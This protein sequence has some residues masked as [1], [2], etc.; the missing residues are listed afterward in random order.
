MSAIV[1]KR[2]V[3]LECRAF[4]LEWEKYFFTECFGQAQCL[5]CL[6]TVAVIKEYNVRRHWETQHQ[7]SS[8]ASMSAA[9]R[10]E[11]I[12]TLSGNLQKSTLLFRKQ[13][14]KADK[15]TRAS[16]EVSRFLAR[17][18]KPFTDGDFIKECIMVVIDSLC[19]EKRSA[20]ESVSLSPRT[21]CRRIEMSHSVNDSL[22]TCC[23]NFDAFSLA[24]DE[25]T[26]MKDTA[27]LTIFIRGVTAALQV[28]EEFLQLV[29]LHGTTTGQDIFDAVLQ[30]VKQHSLGLVCVTTDG[31]PAMTG[32]KKGAASLLVRHCEAA[33]HTQPIHKMHCI[34]HQESLCSRSANL[35]D[36]MS[37]VVKVVNSI[38][39]RSLNHRQFQA[40]MDE[41]N[42]HYGD[43][44]YFCEIRWL[45][46]GAMLSRVC[47]LLQE[48]ATF[49]RQK[50]LPGADH[51]SNPQ[52]LARLALLTDITTHLN[53]LNMNLQ[54]KN[55]L[56]T[57][58]YSHITAFEVKLRLWEA[59]L[60]AGQF[61]HFP[62]IAACAP[63]DVDLNT[64]VGIVTSLREEFTSRFTGVRPLA[65]GFKLFTSPF[66]FAVDEAPAPL[67]MELV[68]L[69]CND[70]LKAKYRTA[71]PLSFFRDLV[72]PSNKFPNYIE[73]VKC[74]VAMFGSTYCCE[75][76]FL[77]MKYTK[78]RIR[79]QLSDRHLNDILLLSTSSIDPDIESLLHGKQHQPS[80]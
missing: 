52:W 3:D 13:T 22:K 70:E 58:M 67:Q 15:V 33:G 48:I 75:Q 32:K 68:E 8:F 11:A 36:V 60:A 64:C 45:S 16:Y 78:S 12:V 26:D 72:L 20:F 53:D 46:H 42:A 35:T 65:L 9:E 6:K 62:R 71:S 44:L 27:Q 49:L 55:I 40:L 23:S 77:K 30:C 61:M 4:N 50:N 59:Q 51:F 80:H 76:L 41:V 69:Q 14:T 79:S 37:V 29:P 5:I 66:D 56:V 17:R 18:M 38:L 63:D 31:A 2:K 54:G 24:L 1:K 34:I 43:L 73:H 19:P 39:S 28:Y 7:A 10:K 57:D 47:D 74:I 25:S 21:V